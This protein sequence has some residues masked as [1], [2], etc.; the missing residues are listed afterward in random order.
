MQ[1]TP[2]PLAKDGNSE[3]TSQCTKNQNEKL[4]RTENTPTPTQG[5]SKTRIQQWKHNGQSR[6]HAKTTIVI[7]P[8]ATKP[9]KKRKQT[10]CHEAKSIVTNK[11]KPSAKYEKIL[12]RTEQLDS[13]ETYSLAK[14]ED[15]RL[16]CKCNFCD[17]IYSSWDNLDRHMK[18]K[19]LPN[20]NPHECKTCQIT[21]TRK[22]SL[23]KHEK[24][25]K[26]HR[27]NIEVNKTQLQTIMPMQ[28]SKEQKPVL[29][30]MDNDNRGPEG[31]PNPVTVETRRPGTFKMYFCV[32]CKTLWNDRRNFYRHRKIH[33]QKQSKCTLCCK[34]MKN[35]NQMNKHL[36][37]IHGN[38]KCPECTYR[39]KN[40]DDLKR[41]DFCRQCPKPLCIFVSQDELKLKLH[42]YKCIGA[43][44]CNICQK[45]FKTS[46]TA[47]YRDHMK[48]THDKDV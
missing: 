29:V 14:N 3:Q 21:F 26:T 38:I 40:R 39:C 34:T 43:M 45:Q 15:Q 32:N 44:S 9:S 16:W 11:N 8:L 10:I 41:H 25:S 1:R 18:V 7:D 22:D 28:I 37:E 24:E 23:K 30:D 27:L 12:S 36:R 19:H 13:K 31:R 2:Q 47:I 48:I 20:K 35:D 46:Q 4:E 17:R 6:P 33:F 42:E 5:F